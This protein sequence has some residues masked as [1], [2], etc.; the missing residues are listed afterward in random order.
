[1][2]NAVGYIR[3]ST[4]GQATE[5]V[6]LAAQRERIEAWARAHD[7]KLVGVFEDAGVSGKRA[8]NRP[9]LQAALARA[10]K[11]KAALVVYSLSRLARSTRDAISIGERLDK[12]GADLVSL[13]ESV[14][15]SS[16]AGRMFFVMLSAF[17]QFERDLTSERTKTALAHLKRQGRRVS[18][19]APFGF[20]VVGREL[21]PDASETATV[22]TMKR[23]RA[24]GMSLR[25]IADEL[26][27][28][29]VPG[30]EGGRWYAPRIL[31]VLRAA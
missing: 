20:R 19:Y 9:G 6:S 21:R 30:G 27:R 5:G 1:M 8:D 24:D 15:T 16:A 18:R 12:A 11:S 2:K 10:C 26:N 17:A 3:V 28:R 29:G 7:Y 4:E 13:T 31:R 22:E 25:A 23:L 14:D